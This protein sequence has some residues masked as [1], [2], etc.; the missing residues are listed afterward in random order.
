MTYLVTLDIHRVKAEAATNLCGTQRHLTY[1]LHQNGQ[2]EHECSM[3]QAI[4]TLPEQR[5]LVVAKAIGSVHPGYHLQ[6]RA[7]I[8]LVLQRHVYKISLLEISSRGVQ[9]P[10]EANI[11]GYA[12]VHARAPQH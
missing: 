8:E 5:R 3:H 4:R 10:I 9:S 2:A 12:H 6:P 11:T 7:R 1:R